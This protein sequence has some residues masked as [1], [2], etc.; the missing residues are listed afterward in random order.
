MNSKMLTS[1]VLFIFLTIFMVGTA[2]A[3]KQ[4]GD[5][6]NHQEVIDVHPEHDEN[7]LEPG[8]EF[9]NE[10]DSLAADIAILA[11][12]SG[13]SIAR[14][15][16]AIAAQTAFGELADKLVA[17]Y[18]DSI[19]RIWMEPL[20]GVQGHIEFVGEIPSEVMRE[21][22]VQG[23][24]DLVILTGQGSISMA[25]H[26]QRSEAA[27]EALLDLGYD[28][29]L[30]FFDP[31]G[32]VIQVEIQLP[33]EAKQPTALEIV[34]AVQ[35]R[36]SLAGLSGR[37]AA[38]NADDLNLVVLEGTERIITLT[39]TR[40]GNWLRD[41]GVR[42]CTS[43]WSVSGPNGDGIITAGHCN[44]LNQFEE[45]GVTPYA[46]SY[47]S[48]VFGSSGDVEYHT[49]THIEYDDFYSDATTIRDV[50]GIK[51]TGTMVGGAVCMYGRSSNYRSCNKTVEATNVT[52]NAGGTTV[53]KLVRTTNNTSIGGDSGGGWSFG[54]TAWGITHGYDGNGKSYFMPVQEA[55]SALGVTVK[56]Q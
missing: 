32:N 8:V 11:K 17:S 22:E 18:P 42:E 20:P 21:L 41:D 31:M 35:N 51:T 49:T 4:D 19:S 3:N 34:A 26:A 7:H 50:S 39:H 46:M 25:E 52:V 9:L 55:Q 45:P 38:I 44:G 54:N 5:G 10:A 16:Q 29:S 23:Q 37:A 28:N 14:V 36:V 6:E 47:K 48:G 15:E 1:V 43:G 30:T 2:L 13:Y 33:K 12:E 40:G 24:N 56:T 27:A 53:K